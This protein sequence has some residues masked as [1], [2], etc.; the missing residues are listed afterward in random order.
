MEE[1]CTQNP[2]EKLLCPELNSVGLKGAPGIKLRSVASD[3]LVDPP[4]HNLW[5]SGPGSSVGTAR[6]ACT[7]NSWVELG[8]NRDGVRT[9]SPATFAQLEMAQGTTG[10][11]HGA[12]QTRQTASHWAILAGGN[13]GGRS[14]SPPLLSVPFSLG[15]PLCRLSLQ[16]TSPP[17]PGKHGC[18]PPPFRRCASLLGLPMGLFF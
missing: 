12:S 8:A 13:E 5:G 2:G 16:T 6:W 9:L 14:L 15:F 18:P 10:G 11:G 7:G 4:E 3:Q 17:R 1:I